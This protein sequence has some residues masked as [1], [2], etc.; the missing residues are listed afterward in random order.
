MHNVLFICCLAITMLSQLAHA[1][2]SAA[3]ETIFQRAK[4]HMAA[5]RLAEACTDFALSAELDESVGTLL[6]LG[7]CQD[8]LG[9]TASA[10]ASFNKALVRANVTGDVRRGDYAN[11][12]AVKLEKTLTRL[13]VR[14]PSSKPSGLIVSQN[15]DDISRLLGSAIPVDPGTFAFEVSAPG[16]TTWKREFVVEGAGETIRVEIPELA[17]VARPRPVQPM[18]RDLKQSTPKEDRPRLVSDTGQATPEAAPSE[19]KNNTKKI[20]AIVLFGAGAGAVGLGLKYG[21]DARRYSNA[22]EGLA[23]PGSW[24]QGIENGGQRANRNMLISYSLGAAGMAGG[25]LLYW[26]GRSAEKRRHVSV[27]PSATQDAATVS[28]MGR[29]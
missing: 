1:D 17:E 27:V 3:A 10:W 15:G 5:G 19:S 13:L 9:R 23:S 16:Y 14:A 7:D 6:N 11:D 2:D 21:L 18:L 26:M 4:D 20:A 29:F 28:L 24:D 12:R 8:K 22:A 25:A